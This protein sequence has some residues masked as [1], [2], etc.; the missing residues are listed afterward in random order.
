MNFREIFTTKK[1]LFILLFTIIALIGYQ[2][3][4]SALVGSDNQTFTLFQFFGPIAGGFLGPVFGAVSVLLAQLINFAF[5]GKEIEIINIIRLVPMLL[6]AIYFGTKATK[7]FKGVLTVII[8]LGAM[9]A[10]IIH[11]VGNEAW[12]YS[13]YWLI[14]VIAKVFH[15]NLF[16]RSLGATFTAHAV[17]SVL[18]LYTVPMTAQQ[19]MALIPIVAYERALFAIGI[20]VS[21][22]AFTTLLSKLETALKS[23][24][25][26]RFLNIEKKYILTKDFFTIKA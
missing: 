23:D 21:F 6:A 19:W 20:A 22:I 16:M 12:I 24:S 7:T 17:G 8:P 15:K 25:I 13:M 14:P 9:A 18:W 26:S 1:I 2:I 11:P 5:A 3:N 4:F 10:F